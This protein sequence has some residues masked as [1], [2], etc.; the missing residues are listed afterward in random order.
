MTP[1]LKVCLC[2]PGEEPIEVP[3]LPME[4]EGSEES[5]ELTLDVFSR[6]FK[7][8]EALDIA[9]SFP[10]LPT[11]ETPQVNV[12]FY[13]NG[14]KVETT[15]ESLNAEWQ[16]YHPVRAIFE[17]V[18]GLAHVQIV[19]QVMGLARVRYQLPPLQI[20]IREGAQTSQ[21]QAMM[22]TVVEGYETYLKPQNRALP[23]FASLDRTVKTRSD[24]LD[25]LLRTFN[26]A[27]AY[28]K[29]N[30]RFTLKAH[31]E[32]GGVEAIHQV[33]GA[34]L[35]YM[36]THPDELMPSPVPTGLTYRGRHYFPRHTLV[37]SQRP[38][39]D[40]AENRAILAFLKAV[41]V[42]LQADQREVEAMSETL[43][44]ADPDRE[45]YMD[46]LT[47]LFRATSQELKVSQ[48][49]WHRYQSQVGDLCRRYAEIFA[50]DVVTMP[51]VGTLPEPT[52]LFWSVPAYRRLYDLM[53]RWFALPELAFKEQQIIF[54]SVVR[55]RLYE[56]YTQVRL[57]DDLVDAGFT[58]E[59]SHHYRYRVRPAFMDA[60][61][62][63][64]NT[65]VLRQK[66]ATVRLYAQPVVMHAGAMPENDL[67][68][69]RA[70][71]YYSRE[72]KELL[73]APRSDLQFYTPD[74]LLALTVRDET[75][76]FVVD[77]KY[78]RA[79]DVVHYQGMDLVFKYLFGLR[80]ITEANHVAGLWVLCGKAETTR[81]AADLLA[82]GVA[83]PRFDLECC[84]PNEEGTA[85]DTSP[86][87]A[88]VEALLVT[89]AKVRAQ[90]SSPLAMGQ[91]PRTQDT[92]SLG[93]SGEA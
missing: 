25:E 1:S 75:Y 10:G 71:S 87:L 60:G 64:R 20:L 44:H 62:E 58:L 46:T 91:L 45:G 61:D 29:D 84:M 83:G 79:S 81:S 85:V 5:T 32:V 69:V 49:E 38:W 51:P 92:L 78:S 70:T 9:V 42:K 23:T 68:V 90:S 57:L 89:L 50:L 40:I 72:E 21:L 54:S 63:V 59:S 13:L 7:A 19:V 30:A 55:S 80:G 37:A 24:F 73:W 47:W 8:D 33:D 53:R 18:L 17:E 39:Y 43:P 28:F 12:L 2:I 31:Q 67:G 66:D 76:W 6:A 26:D 82:T 22:T 16:L 88:V 34:T 74:F 77:A 4:G 48:S 52:E 36:V 86:R 56:Y 15:F 65:F 27:F 3:A 11:R 93:L 14:M 35:T 41:Y